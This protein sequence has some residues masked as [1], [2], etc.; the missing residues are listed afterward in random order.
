MYQVEIQIVTGDDPAYQLPTARAQFSPY[1]IG[2][3]TYDFVRQCMQDPVLRE[4]I[5]ARAAEIR[6][7]GEYGLGN[8]ISRKE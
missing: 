4:R 5:K 6:A 2:R 3:K 8:P 1:G 7:N